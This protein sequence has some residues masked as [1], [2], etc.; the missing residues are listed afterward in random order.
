[1]DAAFRSVAQT[2]VETTVEWYLAEAGP[3]VAAGFVDALEAAVEHLCAHPFTGPLRFAFELEVP[4]LRTWPL[5]TYPY[6][7]VYIVADGS[8]DIWRV[9]QARRDMPQFLAIDE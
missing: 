2:D 1:M 3:Q 7:I 9:V 5:R 6:V 8:I 4:E